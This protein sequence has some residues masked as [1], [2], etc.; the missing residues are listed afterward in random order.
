MAQPAIKLVAIPGG[1][2]TIG[3]SIVRALLGHPRYRPII[4]SRATAEKPANTS[5]SVEYITPE[6]TPTRYSSLETRYVDYT[7]VSSL[8]TALTGVY[9]VISALL[10]TD[11][12]TV[13]YHLNLLAA[14]V[15]AKVSRFAPSEFALSQ[16]AHGEVTIDYDKIVIWKS[17]REA[18]EKGDID[19][20]AFPCGMFMNYLAVG[21]NQSEEDMNDPFFQS[22]PPLAGFREGPLMFHLAGP[23]PYVEVPLT[24]D[25]KF[26]QLSMTDI[27][28]VGRFV[29][30]ALDMEEPWGGRELGMVGETADMKDIVAIIENVLAKK[31]DARGATRQQLQQRLESMDQDDFLGRINVEYTMVCG[32]GGS[33]VE[34]TLNRL[35]PQVLP[36]KIRGFLEGVVKKGLTSE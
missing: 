31:V 30:A 24:L 17:V 5:S 21:L 16:S 12:Q 9:A 33:I 3:S 2:G 19:A 35:C 13:R 34:G 1:S 32:K 28:D 23:E 7:S 18:V 4:L 29:V 14:S 25:G 11:G 8:Q 26:P 27:R 22:A 20:A 6:S 10:V 15:A 36:T